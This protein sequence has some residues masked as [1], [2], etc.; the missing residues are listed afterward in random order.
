LSE[1]SFALVITKP[2]LTTTICFLGSKYCLN[3]APIFK[4]I[5]SYLSSE[6]LYT[7]INS[8][9]SNFFLYDSE[10]FIIDARFTPAIFVIFLISSS[11][12]DLDISIQELSQTTALFRLSNSEY[13]KDT[14]YFKYFFYIACGIT[15]GLNLDN[16]NKKV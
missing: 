3:S 16:L 12:D 14:K 11:K 1:S 7:I 10:N 5:A 4:N 6:I 8:A 9:D 2:V 13:L 15:E